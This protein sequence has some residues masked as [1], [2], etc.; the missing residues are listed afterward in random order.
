[1][2]VTIV[3]FN[4]VYC[5]GGSKRHMTMSHHALLL[6][7]FFLTAQF[8]AC[9]TRGLNFLLEGHVEVVDFPRDRGHGCATV[10]LPT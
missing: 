9:G 1:M 10:C 2:L 4:T 7:S 6:L 3:K 5:L 8:V